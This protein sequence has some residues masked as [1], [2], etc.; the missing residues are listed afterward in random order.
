MTILNT[1]EVTMH[2]ATRAKME[3]MQSLLLAEYPALTLIAVG[4]EIGKLVEFR[5]MHNEEVGS[6]DSVSETHVMTSTKVPAIADLFD[7]CEELGLDPE[8]VEADEETQ[9]GSVVGEKYKALYAERGHPNDNGDSFAGFCREMTLLEF[10]AFCAE[11][12]VTPSAKVQ[13]VIATA[14]LGWQGRARMAMGNSLRAKIKR[15]EA[16]THEGDSIT[17]KI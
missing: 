8:A 12:G 6:T 11:N 5:V 9:S 16:I 2:H 13:N 3:R 10:T 15:G 7:A 14:A 4:D 1:N 17:L